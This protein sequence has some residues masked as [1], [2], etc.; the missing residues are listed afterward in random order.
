MMR[1]EGLKW[2]TSTK[3]FAACDSL[4]LRVSHLTLLTSQVGQ[5]PV[6]TL[7]AI[8]GLYSITASHLL[9]PSCDNHQCSLTCASVPKGT[10]LPIAE[11]CRLT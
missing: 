7:S 10:T 8:S 6:G 4:H 2:M 9:P 3:E 5:F 1:M 11:N